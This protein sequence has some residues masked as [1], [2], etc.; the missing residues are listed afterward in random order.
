MG[1]TFYRRKTSYN[2]RFSFKELIN[3]YKQLNVKSPIL[4]GDSSGYS[5]NL[6]YNGLNSKIIGYEVLP[7]EYRVLISPVRVFWFLVYIPIFIYYVLTVNLD[8]LYP[9][10]HPKMPTKPG[11]VIIKTELKVRVMQ[12]SR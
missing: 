2:I 4:I 8:V 7:K 5:H 10:F 3:S 12:D 9:V 6:I 11:I 1:N